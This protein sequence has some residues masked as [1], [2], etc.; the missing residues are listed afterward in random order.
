MTTLYIY[1]FGWT[2]IS[3]IISTKAARLEGVDV[4][5]DVRYTF[6]D[7]EHTCKYA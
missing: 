1:S 6:V 7:V 5:V 4:A 2:T 3:G